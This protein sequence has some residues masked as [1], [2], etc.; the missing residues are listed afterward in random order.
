M[1]ASIEDFKTGWY[2]VTLGFKKSEIDVL[3]AGLVKLRD[4]ETSHFH[5]RSEFNPK[6]EVEL[7]LS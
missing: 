4:Q 2:G 7:I 5:S 3:V 1:Q 6:S